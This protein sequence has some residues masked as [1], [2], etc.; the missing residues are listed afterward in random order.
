MTFL[1]LRPL[2]RVIR[3]AKTAN[4]FE[5]QPVNLNDTSEVSEVSAVINELLSRLEL[6][7][8]AL[9]DAEKA[10]AVS[11]MSAQVAHDIRAPLL[12]LEVVS[13]DLPGA[14][15]ETCF[16]F[17]EAIE[18]IQDISNN[19]L[20]AYCSGEQENQN[21]MID[22]LPPH[23]CL[24][25]G[26]IHPIVTEKKA[27]YRN[28]PEIQ[29]HFKPRP[30]AQNLSVRLH[31]GEFKRVLSN[32][33]DNAVEAIVETGWVSLETCPAGSNIEIVCRDSGRGI[34]PQI[35][36]LLGREGQTFGKL[37]GS[38]LGLFQAKT[39]IE[40]WGGSLTVES[41][42]GQGTQVSILLPLDKTKKM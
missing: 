28:R 6:S 9:I 39:T 30:D 23:S 20:R 41:Q 14:S 18:R 21:R 38:G 19:L 26:L 35:L 12:A 17:R 36:P 2:R 22:P 7:Q 8:Q 34:P 27:Q 40:G 37:G 24:I 31:P 10:K 4:S 25:E 42:T 29:I 15:E 3:W 16:I 1:A 32:L 11:Q 13:A 5:R 33:I